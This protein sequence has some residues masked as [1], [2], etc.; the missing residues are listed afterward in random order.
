MI[1][2]NK[3]KFLEILYEFNVTVFK[4]KF[5]TH[6]DSI[7]IAEATKSNKL[8]ATRKYSWLCIFFIATSVTIFILLYIQWSSNFDTLS[9]SESILPIAAVPSIISVASKTTSTSTNT[10]INDDYLNKNIVKIPSFENVFNW[11]LYKLLND[12]ILVRKTQIV[13]KNT[14]H[15]FAKT[16]A[17]ENRYSNNYIIKQKNNSY[18]NMS[19]F[20]F[21]MQAKPWIKEQS[22]D[23][24][25]ANVLFTLIEKNAM[26]K[27]RTFL[28]SWLIKQ[29]YK[30]QAWN[31]RIKIGN[32]KLLEKNQS[33]YCDTSIFDYFEMKLDNWNQRLKQM[34][35]D[36]S[37]TTFQLSDIL[38]TSIIDM[39]ELQ[40]IEMLKSI[41]VDPA[42][43]PS[44]D[45]L[46]H[47]ISKTVP[48][49]TDRNIEKYWNIMTMTNYSNI[50]NFIS[51]N[52][53]KWIKIVI[54]RDPMERF[55]SGFIDKCITDH[56]HICQEIDFPYE[57]SQQTSNFSYIK[58]FGH[59]DESNCYLTYLP[60]QIELKQKIELF[61]KFVPSLYNKIMYG[62]E[63]YNYGWRH[64]NIHYKPQIFT[65][66]L[67]HL[68]EYY[69][70]III[71]NKTT[72]SND[73]LYIVNEIL[74]NK[75]HVMENGDMYLN[76]WGVFRNIS[77]FNT[78]TTHTI[79][80]TSQKENQLL[81]QYYS[82]IT[83]LKLA[84]QL[85]KYDY[86]LLPFEY[87]PKFVQQLGFN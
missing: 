46:V 35:D 50:Y 44:S 62:G 31:N 63:A 17:L 24:I 81:K 3:K 73:I 23:T 41:F 6:T 22:N 53:Q 5:R 86:M 69:D 64:V 87:P 70:Y 54:L 51:L 16:P 21:G 7:M 32:L 58:K 39:A 9:D 25:L 8:I 75:Y 56:R 19:L 49:I 55:L 42:S 15:W 11:S 40:A 27:M 14:K 61:D 71:Y 83:T 29:S 84:I 45:M 57:T 34:N 80:T 43:N 2:T 18:I 66:M 47:Y 65:G 79:A 28:R 38:N 30:P 68:I 52:N 12:T 78:K 74:V 33:K 72:F 76:H 67:Y 20:K 60:L 48:R 4:V 36:D 77:L 26:T 82:N 13:F 59:I 37:N 1:Q 10:Q 85:Y